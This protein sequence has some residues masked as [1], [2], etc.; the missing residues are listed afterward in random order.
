[1]RVNAQ[2]FRIQWSHAL[3][4]MLL[5]LLPACSTHQQPVTLDKSKPQA[6]IV[7]GLPQFDDSKRIDI[8]RENPVYAI[9][10]ITAKALQ[11]IARE[12]KRITYQDANPSLHHYCVNSM[13]QTIKRRLLKLGYQVKDLDMTYWQAQSAYRNKNARLKGVDALLRVD[14][15]RFGYFS[16]S[17]FKPYRPGMVVAADLISTKERKI[18]SSNVYNVGYDQDDISKFD[19][20]I[21]YMTNIHVADKRYFYRNFKALMSHAKAS[22]SALKFVAGVAAESVAGDMEKHDHSYSLAKRH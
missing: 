20:Q 10:G 14:I 19:L 1:M 12:Y 11:Q 21:S 7:I 6:V 5:L 13:R 4:A 15:K 22:S 16:A 3:C 17:P 18:L 9:I 8:R 2:I